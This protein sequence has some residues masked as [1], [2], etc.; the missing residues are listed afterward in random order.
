VF[1]DTRYDLGKLYQSIFGRYD[2]VV[3]GYYDLA[4]DGA[5]GLRFTVP[6]AKVGG[7]IEAVFR[8][9]VCGGD[10]ARE[11]TAAAIAVLLFF[12]ML[13]L[14]ADDR[15]RQWALFANGYRL[16]RDNFVVAA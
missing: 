15:G 10:A 14:H 1:G 13:P 7:Q 5:N 2:F 12:S 11:R 9:I 8:Q 3:A 16:Y 4:F 6:A